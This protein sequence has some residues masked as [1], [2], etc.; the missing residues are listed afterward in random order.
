LIVLNNDKMS[1]NELISAKTN[2]ELIR[3]AWTEHK[4]FEDLRHDKVPLNDFYNFITSIL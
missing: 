3:T 1:N 2:R 4:N